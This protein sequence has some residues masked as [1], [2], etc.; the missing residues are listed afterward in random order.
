MASLYSDESC[1]RY[2]TYAD[3]REKSAWNLAK[4]LP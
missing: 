1:K 3:I 4:L 2:G